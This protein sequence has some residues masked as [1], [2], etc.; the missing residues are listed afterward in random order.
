MATATA[1]SHGHGSLERLPGAL[2]RAMGAR[3]VSRLTRPA[4]EP[5]PRRP[6]LTDAAASD[7]DLLAAYFRSASQIPV[8]NRAQMTELARRIE[9]SEHDLLC[10]LM[11]SAVLGTELSDLL[12]QL[13]EGAISPWEIVIGAVPKTSATKREAHDKLRL[14]L[15]DVGK[16][17]AECAARRIELLSPRVSESRAAQLHQELESLWKLMAQV[18][19]ET[20]LAAPHVRRMIERLTSITREANELERATVGRARARL[21]RIERDAGLRLDDLKRAFAQVHVAERRAADAKNQL[22]QANLRLVV[23]IAKKLRG[24]GLDFLDVIQEGNLGLMRAVEKFDRHQGFQ[25]S[26]Y[27]SWWIRSNIQRAIGDLGRAI[28]LPIGLGDDLSR[29]RRAAVEAFK[30][31]DPL[32]SPDELARRARMKSSKVSQLLQL[33][34]VISIHDSVGNGDGDATFE[35]F[36]ADETALPVQAVLHQELEDLVRRTLDG[37]DPR[38]A[39]VL[40]GRYGIGGCDDRTPRPQ[41]GRDLGVSEERIRQIEAAGLEHL[42]S[43]AATLKELLDGVPHRDET[44]SDDKKPSHPKPSRKR[45]ADQHRA[46][47]RLAKAA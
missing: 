9:A 26:T 6:T 14:W 38:E 7:S 43:Q 21:H 22:V 2:F 11:R 13:D 41:L 23:S 17:D 39:H 28:R 40:R 36:L 33:E 8:P 27:A 35:D 37:L 47:E 19:A 30:D 3:V 15:S 46:P 10:A 32:P 25:F 29:L 1:T 12:R 44:Q 24:R 34:T 20:R 45:N 18:L 4:A 31:G 42:R 5:K 16:L